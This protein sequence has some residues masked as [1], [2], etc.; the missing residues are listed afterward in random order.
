[1]DDMIGSEVIGFEVEA[2]DGTM[3]KITDADQSCLTVKPG[4]LRKRHIIPAVAVVSVDRPHH[5]V[6]V[7]MTKH[8]IADAPSPVDAGMGRMD[9]HSTPDR[10]ILGY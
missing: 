4:F 9:T 6:R 10:D 5:R 2:V 3:G 8:E 1:M 7:R